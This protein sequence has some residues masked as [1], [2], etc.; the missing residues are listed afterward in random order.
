MDAAEPP[1]RAAP[2]LVAEA[3]AALHLVADLQEFAANAATKSQA[4]IGLAVVLHQQVDPNL[5][6]AELAVAAAEQ[7]LVAQVRLCPPRGH[8]QIALGLNRE[9]FRRHVSAVPRRGPVRC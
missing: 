1:A 6:L 7:A 9:R 5:D 4:A 8:H 2:A 3:L